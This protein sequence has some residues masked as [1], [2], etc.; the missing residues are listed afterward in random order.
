MYLSLIS[1]AIQDINIKLPREIGLIIKSLF[2]LLGASLRLN[3]H[4]PK[5]QT[6]IYLDH[7]ID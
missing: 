7:V 1:P 6:I 4:Q 3:S 5:M 2:E